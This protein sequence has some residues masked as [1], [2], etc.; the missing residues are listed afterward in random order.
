MVQVLGAYSYINFDLIN[1]KL[2]D[3]FS[4]VCIIQTDANKSR[5]MMIDTT[6]ID[7][8]TLI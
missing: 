3:I 8:M 1:N 6:D 2:Y 5:K 7:G 4:E